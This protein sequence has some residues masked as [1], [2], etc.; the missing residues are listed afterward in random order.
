MDGTSHGAGEVNVNGSTVFKAN[1]LRRLG[2]S[3]VQV[4]Y[5]EWEILKSEQEQEQYLWNLLLAADKSHLF[6]VGLN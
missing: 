3:V 4:P 1:T 6:D 2:W 5:F